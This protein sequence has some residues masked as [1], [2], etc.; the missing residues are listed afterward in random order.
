MV[1]SDGDAQ[2]AL[3][4]KTPITGG[5]QTTYTLLN[6]RTA[7]S[8]GG[9]LE[10]P[11]SVVF[12]PPTASPTL[13]TNLDAAIW[14]N[15]AVP[16]LARRDAS[17]TTTQY[18]LSGGG[19]GGAAGTTSVSWVQSTAASSPY[20]IN[21]GQVSASV[22]M[23][24]SVA[25][26]TN[27]YQS[28]T[29]NGTIAGTRYIGAQPTS[30]TGY[31]SALQFPTSLTAGG[32]FTDFRVSIPSFTTRVVMSAGSVPTTAS[33]YVGIGKASAI[34]ASQDP[35]NDANV[36][37]WFDVAGNDPNPLPSLI[38]PTVTV[39]AVSGQANTYDIT[40]TGGTWYGGGTAPAYAGSTTDWLPFIQ[41]TPI[42]SPSVVL[43]S[44]TSA[45]VT[46]FNMVTALGLQGSA[47]GGGTV[48]T[49]QAANNAGNTISNADGGQGST[50][51]SSPSSTNYTTVQGSSIRTSRVDLADGSGSN[52]VSL[53][54][55][56]PN[57]TY[58]I[59]LPPDAPTATNQVMSV[60]TIAGQ[61]YAT[62][63]TTPAGSSRQICVFRVAE[64]SSASGAQLFTVGA[65]GGSVTSSVTGC[66]VTAPASGASNWSF[67]AGN[68]I[69]TASIDY[70]A[71]GAGAQ[72][73]ITNFGISSSVAGS[74]GTQVLY[75]VGSKTQPA[76]DD[77]NSLGM[78]YMSFASTSNLYLTRFAGSSAGA[79]TAQITASG[80][81]QLIIEK[82]P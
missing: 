38:K 7:Q 73:I 82:L 16:T 51:W 80:N 9:S 6:G 36:L 64:T 62:A 47:G 17:G 13:G 31:V 43:S 10:V 26:S 63:W 29:G 4:S 11:G 60:S 45:S 78:Q 5:D 39:A 52:T 14:L 37:P 8:S 70:T 75:S 46:N 55:P 15:G 22:I 71:I 61:N 48:P 81:A 30:Q 74:G 27:L 18:P 57:A 23:P 72:T 49:M 3:Y 79:S 20:I 25:S 42:G 44:I 77:I 1:L 12:Q 66:G 24:I 65:R 21:V 50:T 68:Y 19:T 28:N 41:V 56:V 34:A 35:L 67:P 33:V 40:V 2:V 58:R 59:V 69:I 32:Y 53:A 54:G 76:S